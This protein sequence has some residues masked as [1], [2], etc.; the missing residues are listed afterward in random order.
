MQSKNDFPPKGDQQD[1]ASREQS[2][3]RRLMAVARQK[4][5]AGSPLSEPEVI[6][7]SNE[8]L[9]AVDALATAGTLT[10]EV[11]AAPEVLLQLRALCELPGTTP[12]QQ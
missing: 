9:L 3:L 2:S 12:R 5:Q 6:A 1:A 11:L 8:I 10:E 4:V 7:L